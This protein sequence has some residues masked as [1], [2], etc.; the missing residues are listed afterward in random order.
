MVVSWPWT[1][2]AT[3]APRQGRRLFPEKLAVARSGED[4]KLLLLKEGE[5]G[6]AQTRRAVPV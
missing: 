2:H 1:A 5:D 3:D 4:L 6:I